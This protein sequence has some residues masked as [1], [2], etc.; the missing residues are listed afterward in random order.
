MRSP[1]RVGN[2]YSRLAVQQDLAART[3]DEVAEP[4]DCLLAERNQPLAVTLADDAQHALVQ[5]DL[6]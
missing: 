4:A 5:V 6:E 2:R 3:R 1:R